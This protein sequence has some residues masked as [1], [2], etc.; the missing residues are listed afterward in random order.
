[1]M[2]SLAVLLAVV[3]LGASP[4]PVSSADRVPELVGSWTCRNPAGALSTVT[5]RTE[6]GAIVADEKTSG[7]SAVHVRFRPDPGGG[8]H[9]DRDTA[10]TRF[11]GYGPAWTNGPWIV[12]DSNKHGTVIRYERVGDGT[13]WRTFS[14]S[15]QAPYAGEV[16]AK[17][18]APPD[19]DLCAVIDVPASVVRAMEPDP[20]VEAIQNGVEGRVEVLVSLDATGRVVNTAIRKSSAVLLNAASLK[21]ARES[22]YRPALHDCKPVASKYL[23]TVDFGMR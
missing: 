4:P 3:L 8:W 2:R 18:D 10:Y 7:A 20:P 11:S 14:I 17:G 13:L 22:T 16:C 1:M 21:S 5:Y 15:G 9:V 6:N 12:T 19:P 23:F